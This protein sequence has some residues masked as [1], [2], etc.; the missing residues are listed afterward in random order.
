[1]RKPSQNYAMAFIGE[2]WWRDHSAS[3]QEAVSFLLVNVELVEQ[4]ASNRAQQ[5]FHGF[6][7]LI[8]KDDGATGPSVVAAGAAKSVDHGGEGLAGAATQPS[9]AE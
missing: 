8:G 6:R 5:R 2:S 3:V 9:Y 4:P 1:M 7:T